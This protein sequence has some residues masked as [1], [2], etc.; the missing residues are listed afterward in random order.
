MPHIHD[1]SQLFLETELI[2][3]D[4]LHQG[5]CEFLSSVYIETRYP[6]DIG[7]L[8]E[9]EPNENDITRTNKIANTIFNMVIR[10]LHIK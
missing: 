3:P 7:H 1:I 5:D 10:Y 6:P 2:I 8:S 9:G 4:Y